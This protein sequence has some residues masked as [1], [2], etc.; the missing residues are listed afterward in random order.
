MFCRTD[1]AMV[2]MLQQVNRLLTPLAELLSDEGEAAASNRLLATMEDSRKATWLLSAEQ[3]LTLE[4]ITKR[5]TRAFEQS[6]SLGQILDWQGQIVLSR[7]GQRNQ[8]SARK[9][10]VFVEGLVWMRELATVVKRLRNEV[11]HFDF[12]QPASYTYSVSGDPEVIRAEVMR[13]RNILHAWVQAV[14]AV[15]REHYFLNFFSMKQLAL[16]AEHCNGAAVKPRLLRDLLF[17]SL[18]HTP[19]DNATADR[20]LAQVQHAWIS[21]R[22]ASVLSG[23]T[24][25]VQTLHHLGAAVDEVFA[26]VPPRMRPVSIA[27]AINHAA[28]ADVATL[29]VLTSSKGK[30]FHDLL[31]AFARSG[32]LPERECCV[33]CPATI[34]DALNL[35]RRWQCAGSNGRRGRLYAIVA[36]D[37]M[38]FEEQ[39]LLVTEINDA[40][41]N[42]SRD[43]PPLLVVCNSDHSSHITASFA[44]YRITL[45]PLPPSLL[46]ELGAAAAAHCQGLTLHTSSYAGS[47][48]SFDIRTLA[49][50]TQLAYVHVP[51]NA[52]LSAGNLIRRLRNVLAPVDDLAAAY[53]AASGT[54]TRQLSAPSS[55]ALATVCSEGHRQHLIGCLVH[56]DLADSVQ[57]QFEPVLF[58]LLLFGSLVDECTGR[59]FAWN[60]RKIAVATEVACG[61]LID[62]LPLLSAVIPPWQRLGTTVFSMEVNPCDLKVGMGAIHFHSAH[63]D[64]CATSVCTT[65][66]TAY[67]RLLYVL[68]ALV[69]RRRMHGEF[70][71]V[72]EMCDTALV[73]AARA[74]DAAEAH[75]LLVAAAGS[76][77]RSMSKHCI[78]AFVNVMYWQLHE[79]NAPQSPLHG[80]CLPDKQAENLQA[81]VDL[82]QLMKGQLVAFAI[83]TARE[84]AT[85][86]TRQINGSRIER[87]QVLGF[88][89]VEWLG[90]RWRRMEFSNDG[91]PVFRLAIGGGYVFF[92]YYRQ[93][94]NCKRGGWVIDDVID[95]DGA[96]FSESAGPTVDSPWSTSPSWEVNPS[97]SVRPE[98]CKEAHQGNA[99]RVS[100]AAEHS[101]LYLRQPPYDDIAGKPH[102]I[103]TQDTLVSKAIKAGS[104]RHLFWARKDNWCVV[105]SG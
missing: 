25:A 8:E 95:P 57:S 12:Q 62:R 45:L 47:G 93:R 31:S 60:P 23:E 48:K 34:E 11:G 59:V 43:T 41:A 91:R 77:T 5:S 68:A 100:G 67:E 76:R 103:A 66:T 39:Q 104:R 87:A 29:N 61:T 75:E 28:G 30:A 17:L 105:L 72:F 96:V 3:H 9:I 52:A 24:T 36:A 15:R 97:I 27:G 53:A 6:L 46:H 33:V 89:K 70:P 7:T 50:E 64:G 74:V 69:A 49:H 20:Y 99:L 86:Q 10:D 38:P 22:G 81:D 56:L 63:G 101:G 90:D 85:R 58:Q 83:S 92:L 94:A 40:L 71:L 55:K 65:A 2:D 19:G 51:V 42:A 80:A 54:M 26:V 16:L 14:A 18:V 98:K 35:V 88:S 32:C 102:Y 79:M 82:K 73:D 13:L 4:F 37:E 21:A 1:G 84:F 44:A 78:W